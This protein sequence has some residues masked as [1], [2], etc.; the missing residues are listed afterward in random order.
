VVV[1][2]QIKTILS[3]VLAKFRTWLGLNHTKHWAQEDNQE[4]SD[5]QYYILKLQAAVILCALI[6]LDSTKYTRAE[7]LAKYGYE[8]VKHCLG[9]VKISFDAILDEFYT[10]TPITGGIQNMEIECN[11]EVEPTE[12]LYYVCSGIPAPQTVCFNITV[13]LNLNSCNLKNGESC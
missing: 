8:K 10:E 12:I 9:C 7:L 13:H 5:H 4:T 2:N 3:N 11:F 6:Y 1:S